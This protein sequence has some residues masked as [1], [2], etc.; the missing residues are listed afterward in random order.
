MRGKHISYHRGLEATISLPKNSNLLWWAL[1]LL[2]FDMQS[3]RKQDI[4]NTTCIN[5]NT[6]VNL[7]FSFKQVKELFLAAKQ[8]YGKYRFYCM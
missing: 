2:L 3:M 5:Y 8:I 4:M 7:L 6:V 1:P